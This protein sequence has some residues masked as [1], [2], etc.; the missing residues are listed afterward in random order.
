MG[1]REVFEMDTRKE[2]C[3]C[4]TTLGKTISSVDSRRAKGAWEAASTSLQQLLPP[5]GD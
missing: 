1:V 5:L 3:F 2:N 4:Q